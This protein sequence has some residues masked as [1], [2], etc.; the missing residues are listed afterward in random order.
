[1][2]FR[3]DRFPPAAIALLIG[4]CG[5]PDNDPPSDSAMSTDSAVRSD[6]A[7][8]VGAPGA[9]AKAMAIDPQR[10]TLDE[11]SAWMAAHLAGLTTLSVDTLDLREETSA[12]SVS[13]CRMHLTRRSSKVTSPRG[14]FA[15]EVDLSRM[16]AVHAGWRWYPGPFP[17]G[18][19]VVVNLVW[20][21]DEA[22]WLLT[23]TRAEAE[24][25]VRQS[26]ARQSSAKALARRKNLARLQISRRLMIRVRRD[27]SATSPTTTVQETWVGS[28]SSL[29]TRS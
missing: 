21:D 10:L 22:T 6:P 8:S 9:P 2:A 12:V 17:P 14:P 1:M 24:L 11:V 20:G 18:G 23:R 29:P 19:P 26:S 7:A 25:P 4:A 3:I 28:R 16:H 13:D 15:V 5:A 27:S